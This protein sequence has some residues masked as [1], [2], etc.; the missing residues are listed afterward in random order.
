MTGRAAPSRVVSSRFKEVTMSTGSNA[1]A[2]LDL[3]VEMTERSVDA[4]SLDDRTCML[5]RIAA[6]V[7]VDAPP[8]SYVLNVGVAS[9][10][11]IGVDEVQGVLAAVAP[12]VGTARV[13]S[14]TGNIVR[15]LGVALDSPD[16]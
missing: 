13:A 5:V 14:A 8:G 10:L 2:V 3:L 7:A 12:I 11:G 6:L 16:V 15:A 1:N 9:E 4:S